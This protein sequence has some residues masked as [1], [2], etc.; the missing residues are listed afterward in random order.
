MYCVSGGK[1]C[2]GCGKC[3]PKNYICPVCGCEPEKVYFDA[4]GVVVGCDLCLEM[5]WA[6][7]MT[8]EQTSN[9]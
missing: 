6:E 8:N 3:L 7:D 2:D 5:K 9:L 4:L 1:E